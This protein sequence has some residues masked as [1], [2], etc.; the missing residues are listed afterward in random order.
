M[1]KDFKDM[2]A[3]EQKAYV[4]SFKI[5]MPEKAKAMHEIRSSNKAGV[6]ETGWRKRPRSFNKSQAIK[7]SLRGE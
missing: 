7:S 4:K 2:T 1:P 3:K 6:I 5:A